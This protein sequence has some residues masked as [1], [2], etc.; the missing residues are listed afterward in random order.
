MIDSV[1]FTN[2]SEC[3]L[4][5]SSDV[6]NISQLSVTVSNK[7][8]NYWLDI[9][10][11][12]LGAAGI[13]DLPVLDPGISVYETGMHLHILCDQPEWFTGQAEIFNLAG[14]RIRIVNL[15]KK[16]ETIISHSLPAGLFFIR[17]HFKDTPRTYKFIVGGN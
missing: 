9:T 15:E 4:L 8:V 17:I 16:S 12:E 7:A 13:G 2:A 5:L 6:S 11:S 3:L 1:I 10:S 14:Q